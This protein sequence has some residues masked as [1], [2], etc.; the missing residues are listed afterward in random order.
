MKKKI[1]S[2]TYLREADK[3]QIK[4]YLDEDDYYVSVK[5]LVHVTDKFII[6][7]GKT[8]RWKK[9]LEKRKTKK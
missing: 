3:Y 6:N 1:I 2:K 8:K 4:L 5:K 9:C 7:N